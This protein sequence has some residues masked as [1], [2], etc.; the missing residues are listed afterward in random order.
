MVSENNLFRATESVVLSLSISR[1]IRSFRQMGCTNFVV[2]QQR[3]FENVLL[4][5]CS[6]Q[7]ETIPLQNIV[8]NF[9]FLAEATG[10][11]TMIIIAVCSYF[12]CAPVRMLPQIR[13]V[14][15]LFFFS[16]MKRENFQCNHRPAVFQS[17]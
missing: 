14:F 15:G 17:L 2:V 16:I 4:C 9:C 12:G 1:A 3:F 13:L 8:G 6:I 7:T 11:N 5:H 10:G